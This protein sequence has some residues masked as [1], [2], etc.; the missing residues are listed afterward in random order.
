[1]SL[2]LARLKKEVEDFVD[3]LSKLMIV[4]GVKELAPVKKRIRIRSWR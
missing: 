2:A 1:M 4:K 3:K